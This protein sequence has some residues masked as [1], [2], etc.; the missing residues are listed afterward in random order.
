MKLITP[1]QLKKLWTAAR[2]A[3][4]DNDAV[5]AMLPTGKFST[6]DLTIAEAAILIDAIEKQQPPNYENRRP[7]ERPSKPRRPKGVYAF[8][9]GPQKNTIDELRRELGWKAEDLSDWLSKRH[10]TDGRPMNKI[11]SSGDAVRVIELLKQVKIKQHRAN[12]PR[13]E[14]RAPF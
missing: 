11:D 2:R 5:H 12:Q 6:K 8:A 10:F 9:T 3:G 13:E 14:R 7:F 1:E 4:H